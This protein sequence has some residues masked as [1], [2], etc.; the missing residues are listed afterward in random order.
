MSVIKM[1]KIFIRIPNETSHD[2]IKQILKKLKLR[3]KIEKPYKGA[4]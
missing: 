2:E 1:D 4:K 3:N